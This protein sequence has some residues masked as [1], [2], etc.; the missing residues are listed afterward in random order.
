MLK[1]SFRFA[2]CPVY[3]SARG[4][5]VRKKEGK[6]ERKRADRYL[7]Q[8]HDDRG[9]RSSLQGKRVKRGGRKSAERAEEL[10]MRVDAGEAEKGKARKGWL[11][12]VLR[13]HA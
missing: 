5:V 6:G 2:V 9:G 11:S 4:I 10:A 12:H 1:F 7:C 8:R 13:S 3:V